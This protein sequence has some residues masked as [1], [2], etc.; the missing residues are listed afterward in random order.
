M[1]LSEISIGISLSDLTQAS[2]IAVV[3]ASY[4]DGS[5]W[6][7]KTYRVIDHAEMLARQSPNVILFIPR[8]AKAAHS[9]ISN[10]HLKGA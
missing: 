1:G 2:A 6:R 4:M 9:Q 10:N 7:P 5:L 8:K 3:R